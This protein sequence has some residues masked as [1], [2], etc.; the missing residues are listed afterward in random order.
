[1]ATLVHIYLTGSICKHA[2]GCR[3]MT[4]DIIY[5]FQADAYALSIG[6]IVNLFFQTLILGSFVTR[7]NNNGDGGDEET[8]E[9]SPRCGTICMSNIIFFVFF[10]RLFLSLLLPYALCLFYPLFP[11][12]IILPSPLLSCSAICSYMHCF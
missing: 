4:I 5:E 9:N 2:L 1:M 10:I 12:H 8:R 3:N 7:D 6:F 11:Q